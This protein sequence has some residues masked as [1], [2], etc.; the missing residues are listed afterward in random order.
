MP[1]QSPYALGPHGEM[2]GSDILVQV[3]VPSGSSNFVTIGSQRGVTFA[4]QTN[5]ID[6]SS[7]EDRR[8]FFNPGRYTSTISF[9]YMYIASSSGYQA[10]KDAMRNGEYVR[11]QRLER[12]DAI[13]IA[14]CVVTSLS[15]AAP[16]QD[17]V[18]VSA[19]FQLNG[20]WEAAP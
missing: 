19:D 15:E 3:E 13:E 4:E 10:L 11:L 5:P 17:A 12:G 7:K 8:G 1:N 14:S 2:N 9:E 18:I 20:G 16:D 6:M